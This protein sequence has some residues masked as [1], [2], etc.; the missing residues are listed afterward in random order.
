[1]KDR[2][3]KC[4]ECGE[5]FEKNFFGNYKINGF[6]NTKI[7]CSYKCYNKFLTR[8]ENEVKKKIQKDFCY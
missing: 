7:F 2:L 6:K 8:K 4:S 3:C 1:M 5:E